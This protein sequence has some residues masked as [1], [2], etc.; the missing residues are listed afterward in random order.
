MTL[1]DNERPRKSNRLKNWLQKHSAIP[2][3]ALVAI[4]CLALVFAAI[5]TYQGWVTI[6][7][8]N[9]QQR[10]RLSLRIQL[11]RIGDPAGIRIVAPLEIGGTTSAQRVVLKNYVTSDK[12][13]QRDY[14]SAIDVNWNNREGHFLGDV[15]TTEVGRRFVAPPLSR[16]QIKTIISADKSLYFI[17]RLEY[18]D[19]NDYCYYFMRCAEIGDSG[20]VQALVYCGTRSGR[21]AKD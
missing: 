14:I 18:C 5:Q 6:R 9:E 11:E 12:P 7:D 10:P 13:K 19:I 8:R 15:S 3:W 16:Q 17:A 20:F 21:L 2:N 4:G 1:M